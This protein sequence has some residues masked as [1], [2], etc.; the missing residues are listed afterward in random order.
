MR[1]RTPICWRWQRPAR[2][3][4]CVTAGSGVALGLPPAYVAR[5]WLRPDAGAAELDTVGG[6]AAVLSGCGADFF[7]KA[8]AQV[9]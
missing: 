7:T 6:H 8:L 3:C 1:C 2:I 4:R 9:Q 5:G